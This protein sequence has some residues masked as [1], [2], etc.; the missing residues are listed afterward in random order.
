MTLSAKEIEAIP[1]GKSKHD[2]DGL[3]ITRSAKRG[4]LSF[5]YRFSWQGKRPEV[6]ID[7]STVK[8][9]R[10]KHKALVA[11]V[12]AGKDPRAGRRKGSLSSPGSISF[13]EYARRYIVNQSSGWKETDETNSSRTQYLNSIFGTPKDNVYAHRKQPGLP[14]LLNIPLS[15]ITT[16][17]IRK[18][19]APVY[20]D[21][22][23]AANRTRVRIAA[24]INAAIDEELFPADRRNPAGSKKLFPAKPKDLEV[25]HF[26]SL[27]YAETRELIPEIRERDFQSAIAL[28]LAILTGLRPTETIGARWSEIDLDSCVWT[29]KQRM[30]NNKVFRVPLSRRAVQILRSQKEVQTNDFVFP[31]YGKNGHVRREQMNKTL[32][33]IGGHD[34]EGV[35]HGFRSTL[36]TF[37]TEVLKVDEALMDRCLSHKVGDDTTRAYLRN[38]MLELRREVMDAWC[39][40]LDGKDVAPLRV[41]L[42]L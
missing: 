13:G 6:G 19:L 18:A 17:D 36:V 7:A 1:P 9:A 34:I 40:Y 33:R 4:T 26:P 41:V 15:A 20:E 42:K 12:A 11:E 31:S 29:L 27:P 8:E 22:W 24:I 38:D 28:E 37:G 21:K 3:W 23:D 32:K 25:R 30:K 39:D 16:D 10:I 14:S 2:G 35:V 5:T